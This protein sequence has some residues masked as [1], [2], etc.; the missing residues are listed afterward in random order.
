MNNK[1]EITQNELSH[2]HSL[3]RQNKGYRELIKKLQTEN[4]TLK[5]GQSLPIDSVERRS[6]QCDHN[7]IPKEPS[8]D[9]DYC[10]CT[11]CG[12]YAKEN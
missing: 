11:K 9:I 6:E 10:V 2:Y 4:Y 12:E 5:Q 7:L 1:I 8:D 3:I